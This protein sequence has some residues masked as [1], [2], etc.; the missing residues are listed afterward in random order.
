[1]TIEPA[2]VAEVMGG[3]QVLGGPVR[4]MFDLSRAVARGLPKDA[5][6]RTVR[7]VFT[8]PQQANDLM[9]RIVAPATYKRRR[10]RLKAPESERTERLARVIASA[11]F[12]WNN[13]EKAQR[14]L[15][16]PHP[17]LGRI[18]PVECSL[19]ELGARQVEELLDRIYYGL[20]V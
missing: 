14:W 13:P 5:L 12:V 20:P 18:S 17:E 7:R 10:T 16:K 4:T 15:V 19:T 9:F 1:M 3:P 8:Q 6:K 11:E 2:R